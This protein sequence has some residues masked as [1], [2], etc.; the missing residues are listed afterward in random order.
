MTYKTD[1]CVKIF[2]KQLRLNFH[3]VRS[4]QIKHTMSC[5]ICNTKYHFT[6]LTLT[7][8]LISKDVYT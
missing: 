1:L 2:D 5:L 3:V 8:I 7:I 6:N 4:L